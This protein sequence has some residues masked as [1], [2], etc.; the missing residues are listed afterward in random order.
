MLA[1]SA[2]RMVPTNNKCSNEL[3][4]SPS[5]LDNITNMRVF[6]DDQQILE[7]VM[8]DDTFKGSIID[9]EEH[10][11]NLQTGNFIPKGVRTLE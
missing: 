7:C 10:Q 1:T 9:D 11:A 3:L 8:N 6:D 4:F 5:V 2:A